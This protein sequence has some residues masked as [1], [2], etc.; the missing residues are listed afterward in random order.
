MIQLSSRFAHW[1]AHERV[2]PC[3]F[4]KDNLPFGVQ[5]VGRARNDHAVIAAARLY[6]SHTNWHTKHPSIS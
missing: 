2:V 3:G 1:Q 6:Q 5:F 4:S